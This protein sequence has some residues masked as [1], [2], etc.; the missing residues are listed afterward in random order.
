[1]TLAALSFALGAALLQ[2][3]PALP[4]LWWALSLP[5]L[6]WLALR[7]PGTAF[8]FTFV[9]GF[10]WAALLAHGRMADWL[11]PELEGRDL[12]V[13]GVV[14][15]LPAV[16][17]RSVRFELDVESGEARLPKKLLLSWYRSP[18][19]EEAPAVLGGA[20]HPGERWLFT[21]RLRRPHGNVNPQGFDYEAWLLER[22]IGATG[23]VRNRGAQKLLGFRNSPFDSIE[24]T[25]EAVRDRFLSTLGPTPAA[26]IL[27]ALAVGDQRAISG[28]EW[29]L[30]NRTGVTHLMS[31]SGLHV[32][33]VS[34]LFAWLVAALW[35]RLP[36][37]A[38]RLPA[39]KAAAVAAIAGALGYSLIAGFAVP[40]QRTFYM[41]TVVALAL[42]SGR[43]ASPA[44]VLALA[45]AAV[46]IAD[47]WAPLAPGLWLSFGAVLL[48]FYVA[49]GWHERASK[50]APKLI[51][52]FVPK[53]MQW[54][55]V[56]WAITVG[57]APAALLLFGQVSVAGPL[58]NAVAIPVISVIVTP[59]ALVAAVVPW[60]PLLHIAAWLVEWLLQFLEWC[61]AL[62]GALWQQHAPPLWS[63]ILALG[64]AAWL[65]APRG[66]PWRGGGLALM[67]PAFA[68][69]PA[70]PPAGEAWITTLDVGQGL[71]V[72]VRTENRVLLYDAGPAFGPEADSGGRIVLP[73]L[74]GAGLSR[75]DAMVLSHE[76]GD[77]IGGALTV[78]ES[79]EVGLLASSLPQTHPLNALVP[80]ALPCAAGTGWVWDGVRFEFLHP[81]AGAKAARR[82]DAS[83]VLRIDTAGGSMLLTGD[84]ERAAEGAL[85]RNSRSLRAD[86]LLVPHHG[87]RTSS[88]AEFI[89]AVAPRWA[90]VPVGYRSRF[91]HPNAEV[92]GRY[93]S[94]GADVL[95]TDRDGA[96]QV[97]LTRE[98]VRVH[99]ERSS[100]PRYWRAVPSV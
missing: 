36:A 27:A 10:L 58:A 15:G 88:T 92:L 16:G 18:L 68:L 62:P 2:S 96:V 90:V 84:I 17:E 89:G 24:K 30:F 87:S 9:L 82:N 20:L 72:L 19:Y 28:E 12:Q 5:V 43:I 11:A 32:T 53:F 6:G 54:G 13:V 38:L 99:S 57:L 60:D 22:G 39:R 64:G 42:W 25:R 71:A 34:G 100:A 56:Q 40:A 80:G 35:R 23:Y 3:Q 46:V 4:S 75:L 70:P 14:S 51:P 41:V 83:C 81:Q 29:Q 49:G 97:R 98:G 73:L 67:A 91:G 7:K 8:V 52:N 44:R 74:R 63:V 33:L 21:V 1:M 69:A 95:R 66:F 26:G 78:L 37:L 50:P 31:I 76:D 48:I 85:V 61:S 79:N 65:L 77:H 59:I 55:R 94:A 93:R 86:V 45:L 47:P